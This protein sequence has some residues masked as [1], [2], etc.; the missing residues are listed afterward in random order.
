[1]ATASK[2][3]LAKAKKRG[4]AGVASFDPAAFL[5]TVGAGRKI[6]KHSK[7]EVIFAQGDDADWPAPGFVDTRLN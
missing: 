2:S 6:G 4:T 7:K 5:T 3:R 1:L